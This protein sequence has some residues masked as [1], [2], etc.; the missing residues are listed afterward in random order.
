MLL[1]KE[2][3]KIKPFYD[4]YYPNEYSNEKITPDMKYF[5]ENSHCTYFLGEKV[6]D[7]IILNK[8]SYGHFVTVENVDYYNKQNTEALRKWE[9]ENPSEVK[10]VREAMLEGK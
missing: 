6:L 10:F 2:L 1:E 9:R 4:F 5:F 8:G 7:K 3:A